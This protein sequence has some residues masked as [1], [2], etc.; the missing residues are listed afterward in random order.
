MQ[1]T[2]Q[3][4]RLRGIIGSQTAG[5]KALDPD[6]AGSPKL[7]VVPEGAKPVVPP[8]TVPMPEPIRPFHLPARPAEPVWPAIEPDKPKSDPINWAA[9][10]EHAA[11]LQQLPQFNSYGRQAIDS[12]PD[13]PRVYAWRARLIEEAGG[14]ARATWATPVWYLY[15][16]RQKSALL[17]QH[18]YAFNTTLR[19]CGDPEERAE[20]AE[21][22]GRLLVR[23]AVEHLTE[24]A[25]L[26]CARRWLG[27][28]FRGRFHRRDL[29]E[30]VDFCDAIKRL[31]EP[32]SPLGS[33][34]LQQAIRTEAARL[35]RHL[36]RRLTRF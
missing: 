35:P 34:L 11:R 10:A 19:F 18:F 8:S 27:R 2:D 17:A 28:T 32:I 12:Q 1:K 20:L 24:R 16:P 4:I 5:D 13:D 26:R 33:A 7:I 29:R 21:Q 25:E 9:K 23:Q 30:A 36:A 15:T 22:I 31:D 14:F 6:L 3:T